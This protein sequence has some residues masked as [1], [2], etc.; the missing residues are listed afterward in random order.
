MKTTN[1]IIYTLL[2]ASASLGTISCKS[3]NTAKGGAIGGAAGGTLGGVIAGKDNTAMGVL[4]GA[5]V[6][7][8]AGALIGNHMDKAADELE[9]DLDGA[10]VERVGE[11]IKITFDSGLMFPIDQSELTEASKTN[12]TELAETLKKYEDTNILIEG[13]TDNTG[14]EEYN[15]KL[16][17][18]RAKSVESY[19]SNIG[20][21]RNRFEIMSYGELQPIASND[22]EDGRQKNRRVEVAVYANKKMKKAA[23]RGDLGE[24]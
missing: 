2:I 23:E 7:G 16:A 13:H 17:K 1:K 19:L 4:I 10:E 6:G 11:G 21:S 9:R 20:I 5:V 14:A 22:T 18:K 12:L 15:D 24:L 3:S 8:S